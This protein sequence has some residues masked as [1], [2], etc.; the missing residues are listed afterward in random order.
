[1]EG[2]LPPGE[3]PGV[4]AYTE[5]YVWLAKEGLPQL[6]KGTTVWWLEPRPFFRGLQRG[7][8]LGMDQFSPH[9]LPVSSS[10]K[11]AVMPEPNRC[12]LHPLADSWLCLGPQRWQ[13]VY[14]CLEAENSNH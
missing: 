7:Q 8:S 12:G 3:R 4:Q 11:T 2:L 13:I 10:V 9:R 5:K 1:M 6:A 14:G